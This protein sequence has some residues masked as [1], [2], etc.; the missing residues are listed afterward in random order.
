M[1]S[2]G[3]S[4]FV[5]RFV[6][7]LIQIFLGPILGAMSDRSLS[8]WGRRNVFL[9][10]A[11]VIATVTGLLYGSANVLFPNLQ[12]LTKLLLVLLSIGVLLLNVRCCQ[13]SSA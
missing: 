3:I 6:P 13:I 8:N 1:E 4:D 5:P 9:M 12:A 11:A 2:M 7:S 10:A